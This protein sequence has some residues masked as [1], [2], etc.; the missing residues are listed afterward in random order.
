MTKP[1]LTTLR[2]TLS[3]VATVIAEDL[4]I[5]I[6]RRHPLLE[7]VVANAIFALSTERC[8]QLAD[9]DWQDDLQPVPQPLRIEPGVVHCKAPGRLEIN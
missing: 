5:T 8:E 7:Q 3:Q 1:D 2:S 4:L 6:F 9:G